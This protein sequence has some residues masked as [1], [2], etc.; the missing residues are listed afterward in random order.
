MLWSA[1]GSRPPA[2]TPTSQLSLCTGHQQ[3]Q[4]HQPAQLQTAATT[5]DFRID[6]TTDSAAPFPDAAAAAG[7]D[8]VPVMTVRRR[9]R[10]VTVAGLQD[11]MPRRWHKRGWSWMRRCGRT[12]GQLRVTWR[13]CDCGYAGLR[14]NFND[15][16]MSVCI[17]CDMLC[18]CLCVCLCVYA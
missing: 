7:S 18:S 13:R 15:C 4:H 16:V 8:S 1:L 12:Y 9:A 14:N 2:S 5:T 6:S 11:S 17:V 3:H 10:A